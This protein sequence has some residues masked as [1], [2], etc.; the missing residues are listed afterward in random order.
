MSI[1][2]PEKRR[3]TIL[4]LQNS[5]KAILLLALSAALASGT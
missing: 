1:D 2:A 4:N 5:T 3:L